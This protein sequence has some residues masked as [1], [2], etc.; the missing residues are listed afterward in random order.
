MKNFYYTVKAALLV[1]VAFVAYFFLK[2]IGSEKPKVTIKN[3]KIRWEKEKND[4]KPIIYNKEI[5]EEL[6]KLNATIAKRK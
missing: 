6:A 5:D 2:N 1:A 4:E 3:L